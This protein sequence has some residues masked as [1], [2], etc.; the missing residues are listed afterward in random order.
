[1]EQTMSRLENMQEKL[2]QLFELKGNIDT[3]LS[4]SM[5]YLNTFMDSERSSVFLFHPLNQQLTVFSSLDL[6][7]HEIAIPKESGVAG[8]VFENRK[9][10]IVDNTCED[11]R[12][13]KWVDEITGFQTHTIICTP[14]SDKKGN[15]F[16]T[17]QSLN[18][19]NGKFT[20]DDLEL[21][22]L[23]ASMVAEVINKSG[24]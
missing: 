12:F 14:L 4:V 24:R 13:C 5:Y 18:K 20:T 7:K 9:A 11:S 10:T 2:S 22:E 21:M 1:M 15:C 3:M 16:G 23:A 8:W 6:E 19:K 17:L